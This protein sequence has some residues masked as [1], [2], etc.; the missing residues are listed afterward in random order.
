MRRADSTRP[1]GRTA[2]VVP[3]LRTGRTPA[4]PV[5]DELAA[6]LAG[7]SG[8]FAPGEAPGLD[9]DPDNVL[10]RAYLQGALDASEED[11]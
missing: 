11:L 6:Y 9:G 8:G 3:R 1:A 5:A 4:A 10:L 2:P 7:R